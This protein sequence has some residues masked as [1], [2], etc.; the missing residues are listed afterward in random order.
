[1]KNHMLDLLVTLGEQPGLRRRFAAAK[2]S[3]SAW[4]K[5]STAEAD[6]IVSGDASSIYRA[7]GAD[8]GAPAPKIIFASASI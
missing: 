1:M 4:A 3:I 6:A 8:A 7:A 5:L 2:Q